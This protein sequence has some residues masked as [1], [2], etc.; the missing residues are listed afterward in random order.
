MVLCH[1]DITLCPIGAKKIGLG[2][3]IFTSSKHLLVPPWQKSIVP[4]RHLDLVL[5]RVWHMRHI[6][7]CLCGSGKDVSAMS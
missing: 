5:R 4:V 1:D 2:G 7:C 3:A 6:G